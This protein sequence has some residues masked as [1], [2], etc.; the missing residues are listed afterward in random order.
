MGN[1]VLALVCSLVVFHLLLGFI[2]SSAVDDEYPDVIIGTM[3]FWPIVIL[4]T[5][6]Y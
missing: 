6:N 4:V 1:E 2:I 3:V 5:E